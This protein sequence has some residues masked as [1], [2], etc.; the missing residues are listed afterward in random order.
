MRSGGWQLFSKW[1]GESM[2]QGDLYVCEHV[3]Q[4]LK[5]LPIILDLL[6]VA[7]TGK[8]I[9]KLTKWSVAPKADRTVKEQKK[10]WWM[11][12]LFDGGY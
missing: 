2:D 4:L 6:P 5:Q 8:L 10:G 9:K 11:V 3:L 7:G 1:L 12:Q